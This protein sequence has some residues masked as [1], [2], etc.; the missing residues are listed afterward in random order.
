MA[1]D[2]LQ[3]LVTIIVPIY[4]VEKYLRTCLDTILAQS[5]SNWEAILVDDGSPDA[6]PKIIDEYASRDARMR[7]VHRENGGL[8]AARNSGLRTV[9]GEFI[10]FL[11]SD[12]FWH[13]DYLKHMVGAALEHD[14]DLVQCD[15]TRGMETTFPEIN[16]SD[17]SSI[18]IY[19]RRSI[20]TSFAA[21]V[22]V[23]AKL[24][25]RH[26][27]D[28]IT[29]PEGRVNEDDCTNWRLYYAADK[30]AVI[31]RKLYYYTVNPNSTMG[32]LKKKPDL[33]FIDAY[34]E[35]IA[36]F[37]QKKENDLVATSRIQLLKSLSFLVGFPDKEIRSKASKELHH[38]YNELRKSSFKTPTRLKAIF[39]LVN[40]WPTLG[41]K[42]LHKLYAHGVR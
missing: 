11:D 33:R 27:F 32:N 13:K 17:K 36:F 28:G 24:Y 26:I 8:S 21:K 20:F 7:T 2:S 40:F 10:T 41:S 35:R 6:C 16:Y 25:R 37:K 23:C 9:Q 38:Q 39:T 31:N 14:A 18:K 22:I 19:D 42:V 1:T 12:D 4:K 29:F 5:Y 3:P 30:I 15:F 34:H